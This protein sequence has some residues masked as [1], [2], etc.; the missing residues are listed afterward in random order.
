MRELR[1]LLE[2]IQKSHKEQLKA[3][4]EKLAAEVDMLT[5]DFDEER[6]NNAALKVELDRIKRRVTRSSLEPDGK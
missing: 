2:T 5:N 6:K 3:M 1:K 4:E